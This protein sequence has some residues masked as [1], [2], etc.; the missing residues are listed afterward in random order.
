MGHTKTQPCKVWSLNSM[1]FDFSSY[2]NQIQ[3]SKF[4]TNT[5]RELNVYYTQYC[6]LILTLTLWSDMIISILKLR[7][8]RQ[9]LSNLPS[10]TKVISSGVGIL[11]LEPVLLIFITVSLLHEMIY[12]LMKKMNLY[13]IYK[14]YVLKRSVYFWIT[15]THL[16][17]SG[18]INFSYNNLGSCFLLLGLVL[19]KIK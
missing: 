4:K 8:L 11:T 17:N 2:E 10:I 15:N 9:M 13:F 3:T 14:A 1:N 7:N 19:I 18:F 16:I 5:Y 12:D 6:L